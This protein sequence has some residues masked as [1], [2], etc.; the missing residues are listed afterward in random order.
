MSHSLAKMEFGRFKVGNVQQDRWQ[1]GVSNVTEDFFMSCLQGE[2]RGC[3]KA[4]VPLLIGL[5]YTLLHYAFADYHK[6]R[7]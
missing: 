2:G 7:N 1:A 4:D 5:V 6:A 3:G